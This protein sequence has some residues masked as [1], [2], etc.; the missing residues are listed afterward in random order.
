MLIIDGMEIN[1]SGL[2]FLK[3]RAKGTAA[4]LACCT[5]RE[6][7]CTPSGIVTYRLGPAKRY[8]RYTSLIPTSQKPLAIADTLF[9]KAPSDKPQ[10]RIAILITYFP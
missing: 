10:V 3:N 1:T 8:I 6:I 5:P 7:S 9:A 4:H 2:H